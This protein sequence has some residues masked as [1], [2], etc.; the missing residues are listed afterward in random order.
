[1]AGVL[2]MPVA[3]RVVAGWFLLFLITNSVLFTNTAFA[4]DEEAVKALVAEADK[5][6]AELAS[7]KSPAEMRGLWAKLAS[8]RVGIGD[9]AGGVEALDRVNKDHDYSLCN[10]WIMQIEAAGKL[11]PEPTVKDAKV[12]AL[13]RFGAIS[14]LTGLGDF[15]GAIA[16]AKLIPAGESQQVALARTYLEAGHSYYKGKNEFV[17]DGKGDLKCLENFK[18]AM[19]ATFQ[20][21]NPTVALP[22]TLELCERYSEVA[23]ELAAQPLVE[24]VEEALDSLPPNA[25]TIMLWQNAGRVRLLLKDEAGAKKDF[26][27][28]QA[29]YTKFGQPQ[30]GIA[31]DALA[32]PAFEQQLRWEVL[33]KQ[34]QDKEAAALLPDWVKAVSGLDPKYQTP[35]L[36]GALVDAHLLAGDAAGMKTVLDGLEPVQRAVALTALRHNDETKNSPA[37]SATLGKY[38]AELAR[39]PALRPIHPGALVIACECFRKT[40]DRAKFQACYAEGLKLSAEDDYSHHPQFGSFLIDAGRIQQAQDLAKDIPADK[41]AALLTVLATQATT[42]MNKDKRR[43]AP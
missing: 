21:R 7:T 9:I 43:V 20:I 13:H 29:R 40:G 16:Q 25:S 23:L 15:D 41:R 42:K 6:V 33:H 1:M 14:V 27:T 34:K 36:V 26:E 10:A 4:A 31:W 39:D 11:T 30:T 18:N 17:I 8:A 12:L 28:A 32:Y 35:R 22:A 5:A 24:K 38:C 3:L 19:E 37:A 2:R